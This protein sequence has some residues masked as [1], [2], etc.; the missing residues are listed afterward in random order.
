MCDC[1][2]WPQLLPATSALADV[3][4]QRCL[5]GAI[6]SN[7][8]GQLYAPLNRP[9]GLRENIRKGAYSGSLAGWE[10]VGVDC[11]YRSMV[12]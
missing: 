5:S 1:F 11:D 7:N 3:S 6:K 12:R 10:V 2:G 4:V 8:L 9:S